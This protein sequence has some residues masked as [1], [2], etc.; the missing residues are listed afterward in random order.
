MPGDPDAVRRR[1][2]GDEVL[3]SLDEHLR[4]REFLVGGRY[5]IADIAVYAYTHCCA[6]AGFDL[7]RYP[8]VNEWLL[9]A[10]R[11]P[12]FVND[13]EPYPEN[14]RPGKDRSTYD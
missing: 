12:N 7:A 13:L 5:T 6:E 11:Q 8:A 3:S 2:G 14:A 4:E 10:E 9:R 1:V